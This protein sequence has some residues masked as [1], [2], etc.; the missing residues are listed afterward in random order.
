MIYKEKDFV[1]NTMSATEDSISDLMAD[2]LRNNG[3]KTRT[4]ISITSPGTRDQPDF[5]IN[6]GG[7]FIGEAKWEDKKWEGFGEARDYGQLPGING[8]FLITYPDE[9]RSEGSQAR[10]GNNVAESVLGG[11]TFSCAFLRR[12]E[13]T[14]MVQLRLEKIPEWIESNIKQQKQPEADPNEVVSVLRQTARRL[15]DELE[16]APEEN[17][18]R[19]V[20]GATPEE[21]EEEK[22]AARETAG[23]LL[24]NQITFYR[25][26][27]AH[28]DFPEIDPED[29]QSPADLAEYFELVLDYD[30]TPVFSFEIVN[31]LP[32]ESLSTLRDAIKSIYALSPE[33]ITHDILG[34]VFHELIPVSARKKVAAYYTKNKAADVLANLAIDDADA[35]V[36]DPACGSGTLLAASYIRKRELTHHFTE[37]DHR[38][39]VEK[40]ITG[41]DV[42]PFAAH[43]SCIHLALQA[44]V[45][46]TD[47]VNIG[48]EDS[49]TL[50]PGRTISPLSFVLP[51]ASEQRGL[52]EYEEGQ[53]PDV[54]EEMIEGGSVAMDAVSGQE[55]ELGSVDVVIMNPPSSVFS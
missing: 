4:Q 12:D 16:A 11:H 55:M 40:E 19:N 13:P 45:F 1:L 7:T 18:F 50:E 22:Q 27:S 3:I 26:L 43:L 6:N 46:E 32:Q 39:F 44:P 31:D 47:E 54:S 21:D 30:Y 25:V 41:I 28:K 5:Q 23:F 42:M 33:R 24:V 35:R 2:Y 9:L 15:N 49:T 8:S 20:L 52:H 17:L 14:D 34:K 29:L 51:E 10:I 37:T 48:I 38:R 53:K 36:M